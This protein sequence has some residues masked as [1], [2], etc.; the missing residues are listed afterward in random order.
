MS[1]AHQSVT[2]SPVTM[3]I[4]G[5]FLQMVAAAVSMYEMSTLMMACVCARACNPAGGGTVLCERDCGRKEAGGTD[6]DVAQRDPATCPHHF[7]FHLQLELRRGQVLFAGACE[8]HLHTHKSA[9]S[10]CE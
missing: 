9:A 4:E 6:L 7:I 1:G 8:D 3:M 10:T 5:S 2:S